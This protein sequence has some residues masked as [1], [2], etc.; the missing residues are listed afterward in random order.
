M[1]LPPANTTS[2]ALS[3]DSG[4]D[5]VLA[6]CIAFGPGPEEDVEEAV[7]ADEKPSV[8]AEGENPFPPADKTRNCRFWSSKFISLC[9]VVIRPLGNYFLLNDMR[10]RND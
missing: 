6:L 1:F 7:E 4:F 2:F 9:C 10:V 3:P 5:F 8:V